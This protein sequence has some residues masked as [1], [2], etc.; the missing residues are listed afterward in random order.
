MVEPTAV[1]PTAVPLIPVAPFTTEFEF[2]VPFI[3]AVKVDQPLT[4]TANGITMTLT[5]LSYAPSATL[6]NLCFT[7]PESDPSLV[8]RPNIRMEIDGILMDAGGLY[9]PDGAP[10]DAPEIC[11]ELVILAPLKVQTDTVRLTIDRIQT[12]SDY[13]D[14]NIETFKQLAID[15]GFE[16]EFQ[17]L[18][19][20]EM[21]EMKGE[22][23]ILFYLGATIDHTTVAKILKVPDDIGDNYYG[24]LQDLQ[25][26][27]FTQIVEGPWT[28]EVKLN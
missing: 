15:A 25:D 19:P 16:V 9:P 27:A 2:S 18:K 28:F 20:D 22:G 7:R 26:Q 23:N 6:G 8:W 13:S 24:V 3:P 4:S 10:E 1:E 5:D 14:D 12:Y 11:G 21:P 17:K